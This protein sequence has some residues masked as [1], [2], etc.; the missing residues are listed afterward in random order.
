[1]LVGCIVFHVTPRKG[2]ISC[3]VALHVIRMGVG[4]CM[5]ALVGFW[6][7][8]VYPCKVKFVFW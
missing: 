8:C 5:L 6:D 3:W 7:T 2:W 4:A 1:M